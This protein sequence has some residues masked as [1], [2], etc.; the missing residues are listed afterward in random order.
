MHFNRIFPY[1]P[2]ILGYPHDLGN[3]QQTQTPHIPQCQLD[4]VERTLRTMKRI[5]M[6]PSLEL[7]GFLS[8]ALW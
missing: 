3:P 2:T 4:V 7:L 1:K 6:K 5:K 8:G